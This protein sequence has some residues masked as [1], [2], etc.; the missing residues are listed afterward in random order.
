MNSAPAADMNHDSNEETII[1]TPVSSDGP[2]SK[3]EALQVIYLRLVHQ[4]GVSTETPIVSQVLYR[5]HLAGLL[6]ASE[7]DVKRARSSINTAKLI[8]SRREAFDENNLDFSLKI[9]V[10]GKTGVGKS[11]TINSIFNQTMTETDS[12]QPGTKRIQEV[13]GTIKGMKVT[14]IDTPGLLPSSSTKPSWN[15]NILLKIKKH[16]RKSPP[17]V[18]MYFERLDVI[19]RGYSD[20]PILRLVTEIFGSTIW[21]NT[22]L[23]MTHSSSAVPVE[24]YKGQSLTFQSFVSRS[25]KVVQHYINEAILDKQFE[26]QVLLV[27]N[28]PLCKTNEDGEKILPNGVIWRQQVLLLC[29]STKILNDANRV[30]KLASVRH[31]GGRSQRMPSLPHLLTLLLQPRSL[32]ASNDFDEVLQNDIAYEDDANDCDYDELPPIQILTQ[33]QFQNLSK[34]Q[35]NDYL[36]ELYYRETLYLKNQLKEKRKEQKSSKKE[37]YNDN[38]DDIDN[39][40]PS[41]DVVPLS[42]RSLPPSFDS[43]DPVHRFR[44]ILYN[45]NWLVEP[46]LYPQGWEHDVGFDGVAV[47]SRVDFQNNIQTSIMAQVSKDKQEFNLHSECAAKYTNLVSTLPIDLTAGLNI[48]TVDKEDLICTIRG[49]ASVKNTTR[50]NKNGCSVSLTSFRDMLIGGI[51]IDEWVSLW[52]NIGLGFNMGCVTG[53]GKVAYGGGL[54]GIVRGK[55]YPAR[56][57]SEKFSVGLTMISH[58]KDVVFGGNVCSEFQ[59]GSRQYGGGGC[60]ICV[61]GNLNSRNLG[62]ISMKISSYKQIELGILALLSFCRFLFRRKARYD[63]PYE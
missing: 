22:V 59:I 9:L 40:S 3:V 52:R 10:L 43:D 34:K 27:E 4:I 20:Y 45:E 56:Y 11:A 23:V 32:A 6:R 42:D 12:F 14:I 36:D 7:S 41:P 47:E 16:I 54:E 57:D 24:T 38:S 62:R 53:C 21:L 48:Q 15:R 8:A 18:V 35:K 25:T 60:K 55:N 39:P 2:Y 58:D 17:D 28:H 13:S 63:F 37:G 49:D 33:T 30:L 50:N 1:D 61:N 5:L 46:V 31:A 19:N 29:L 44:S 51:K 26:N